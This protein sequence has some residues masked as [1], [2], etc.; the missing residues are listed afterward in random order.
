M[1]I[2]NLADR[3][4][5]KVTIGDI[6]QCWEWTAY[7]NWR[8][9]GKIYINGKAV[10]AQRVAYCLEH[11]LDLHDIEGRLIL[12][13]CDN[14]GCVNPKHLRAGD[15]QENLEDMQTRNREAIR[16]GEKN[17]NSKLNMKT[18]QIIRQKYHS[19]EANGVQLAKEFGL[20]SSTIYDMLR[21]K[22]WSFV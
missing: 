9:Y 6:N 21:G 18:V 1:A 13:S 16:V 17:P 15:H 22:T 8:G 11:D 14:P 5:K 2:L 19:G 7:R 20:H 12:H 3:F 10:N 4:W